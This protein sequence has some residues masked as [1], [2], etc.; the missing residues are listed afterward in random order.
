MSC[1]FLSIKAVHM[2]DDLSRKPQ[3]AGRLWCPM[4][5]Y[6]FS[7]FS[8]LRMC[9]F[10]VAEYTSMPLKQVNWGISLV[11]TMYII[12]TYMCMYVLCMYVVYIDNVHKIMLSYCQVL[13]CG[14]SG[15]DHSQRVR[16]CEA[17]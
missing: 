11:P 7:N 1:L 10:V 9:I 13:V 6:R 15:C 16:G 17:V 2:V 12:Y 14:S 3:E 5:I 8:Q 4:Q